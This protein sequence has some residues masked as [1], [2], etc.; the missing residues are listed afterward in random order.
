MVISTTSVHDCTKLD[1]PIFAYF[2][3]AGVVLPL[4]QFY[5]AM[6][7]PYDLLL[8]HML[9]PNTILV[10]AVFQ[11][12]CEAFIEI[13]PSVALFT[14]PASSRRCWPGESPSASVTA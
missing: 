3:T 7:A 13:I 1:V 4:S 2:I 5:H 6:L 10:M 14:P 9:H 12:L 11:H 8:A